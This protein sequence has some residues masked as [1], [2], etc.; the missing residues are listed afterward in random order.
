MSTA[1]RVGKSASRR[2]QVIREL[3]VFLLVWVLVAG[4]G[5]VV[6]GGFTDSS[7]PAPKTGQ[8]V[9]APAPLDVSDTDVRFAVAY[10]RVLT[11][12]DRQLASMDDF[13]FTYSQWPHESIE[14]FMVGFLSEFD[15]ERILPRPQIRADL[16]AEFDQAYLT[17]C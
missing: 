7:E 5:R 14:A 8:T 12:L 10:D 3:A 13:C 6:A 15:A 17:T 2:G 16:K 1:F 9:S 11:D 4:V